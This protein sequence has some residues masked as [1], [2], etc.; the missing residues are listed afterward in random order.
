MWFFRDG[1][2]KIAA[3][4]KTNDEGLLLGGF[5]LQG[6]IESIFLSPHSHTPCCLAPSY[7]STELLTPQPRRS[8]AHHN[9][10]PL[11]PL[12]L[13]PLANEG[14]EFAGPTTLAA[15]PAYYA[16]VPFMNKSED[17]SRRYRHNAVH[18]SM[19][20]CSGL[21]YRLGSEHHKFML[22]AD[23][24]RNLPVQKRETVQSNYSRHNLTWTN[25]F[26]FI[27]DLGAASA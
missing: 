8:L 20:A 19:L 21:L 7:E 27:T 25:V 11:I 5:V 3:R 24:G 18:S 22:H 23:P 9:P 12:L 13:H 4:I 1:R 2:P 10:T 6:T 17:R 15:R 16:D 14:A 26:L